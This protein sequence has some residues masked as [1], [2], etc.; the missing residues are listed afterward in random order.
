[1]VDFRLFLI[2]IFGI[3]LSQIIAS[4]H[5][6]FA[7]YQLL[8]KVKCLKTNSYL[9][10]PNI[11]VLPNLERL[12]TAFFGGLFFSGTIGLGIVGICYFLSWFWIIKSQKNKW[13]LGCI[14]LQWLLI[15]YQ[16][17]ANGWS[18][19]N[20]YLL[21]LAPVMFIFSCVVPFP[22]K[23]L[24]N[25]SF[26]FWSIPVIFLALSI[27]LTG[28]SISFISIRDHLLLS[29][30]IG[31]KINDFY[32]KYTLY[33][34]EIIKPYALRQQKTCCI[35]L[36][37]D[38]NITKTLDQ[39]YK[40]IK[41]QCITFDYLII[42]DPNIADLILVIDRENIHFKYKEKIIIKSNVSKLLKNAKSIFLEYSKL[43]DNN[44]L[45][46]YCIFI[47][48]IFGSPI[49]LYIIFMNIAFWAMQI[50]TIKDIF[51]EGILLCMICLGLYL[52]IMQIPPKIDAIITLK[53]WQNLLQE[54]SMENDW[55]QGIALLKKGHK[56]QTEKSNQIVSDWLKHTN[57]PAL[58]YWLIRFF[59]KRPGNDISSLFYDNLVGQQVNV[60]C[61]ALYILG[62]QGDRRAI[63]SIMEIV[64]TSPHWYIQM[65]GYRAL[66]KLGW[67]N[68]P[69][70]N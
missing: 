48:L 61:Q 55:K 67:R 12:D 10:I 11:H 16:A 15:L 59:S 66:K 23:K 50:L 2:T 69:A 58:K 26:L 9:V 20:L 43:T 65:Y 39:N 22:S 38:E 41:K 64:N 47:S 45:F 52:L 24:K 8:E 5:V 44:N 19:F 7:N 18:S 31:N 34:S 57:S 63:P 28:R 70:S 35:I 1:M 68:I 25:H 46:R 51:R 29:N 3:S 13:V 40:E 6:Y 27:V 53:D 60:I 4:I 33:P 54:A 56:F 42:S 32:Y 21:I 62:R 37:E 17:N 36:Q 30:T 49:L 14:V